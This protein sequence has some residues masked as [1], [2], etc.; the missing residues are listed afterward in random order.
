MTLMPDMVKIR[1]SYLCF[2]CYEIYDLYAIFSVSKGRIRRLH[3]LVFLLNERIIHLSVRDLCGLPSGRFDNRHYS[4]RPEIKY[5]K[6]TLMWRERSTST[7]LP[8]SITIIL[9]ALWIV[10]SLQ[11]TIISLLKWNLTKFHVPDVQTHLCAITKTVLLVCSS[12]F[13]ERR[14]PC[15]KWQK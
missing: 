8:L 1:S 5:Y 13:A 12:F 2:V 4:H 6:G 11:I 15:W 14:T 7:I 9:S 10:D 3:L